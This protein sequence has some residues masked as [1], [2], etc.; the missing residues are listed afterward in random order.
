M[1]DISSIPSVTALSGG[2]VPAGPSAASR[3]QEQFSNLF[4]DV[5]QQVNGQQ[6][7]AQQGVTD[8][9]VGATD[10]LHEVVL[11]VAEA[12]LAFQ[13]VLEI[14]NRLISSYQELLRMQV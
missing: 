5:L 10:N 9:A 8:L 1:M 12:D 3:N 13:L 11:N 4:T 14:R 2:G 6:N 7:A